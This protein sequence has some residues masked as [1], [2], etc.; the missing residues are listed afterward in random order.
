MVAVGDDGVQRGIVYTLCMER[1]D[2]SLAKY[3]HR[4]PGTD[5]S[6]GPGGWGQKLRVVMDRAAKAG[7]VCCDQKP[8][9]VLVD[10]DPLDH[11][12]IRRMRL[13]DFG[14]GWSTLRSVDHSID[15]AHPGQT[16][17]ASSRR[18][19]LRRSLMIALFDLHTTNASRKGVPRPF[20]DEAARS[21]CADDV[22]GRVLREL[23]T[24]DPSLSTLRRT[25][26]GTEMVSPMAVLHHFG[27]RHANPGVT[28]VPGPCTEM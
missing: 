3:I 17:H 12:K 20:R 15:A 5:P 16:A 21:V 14:G 9:N 23:L 13:C 6:A 7:I 2:S 19:R 22:D 8:S 25:Y 18:A 27:Y 4:N 24:M 1:M 26:C 10:L 11:S 28:T